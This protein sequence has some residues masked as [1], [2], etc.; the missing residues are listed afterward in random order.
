M[1][2]IKLSELLSQ[3]DDGVAVM[4]P[5]HKAPAS[6][7][8]PVLLWFLG[9]KR[10][11]AHWF[12]MRLWLKDPARDGYLCDPVCNYEVTRDVPLPVFYDRMREH[13]VMARLTNSLFD[14]DEYRY[15]SQHADQL[16]LAYNR[17]NTSIGYYALGARL[18]RTHE[19]KP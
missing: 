12:L 5:A 18:M 3:A 10:D 2:Q 6:I 4:E 16:D 11:P 9:P 15:S 14:H 13:Y 8:P 19:G 1:M 7:H 17:M